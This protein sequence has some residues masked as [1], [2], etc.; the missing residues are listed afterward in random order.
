MHTLGSG[1]DIS[2]CIFV[3]DILFFGMVTRA[4]WMVFHDI[5]DR[6]GVAMSLKINEEKSYIL[7]SFGDPTEINLISQIFNFST[8]PIKDGFTYLGFHLKPKNYRNA[9]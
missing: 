2:H 6:F 1:K 4:Q 9:N 7:Y 3:D 8:Q 5:L